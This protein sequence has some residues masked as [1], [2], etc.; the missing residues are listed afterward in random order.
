MRI[1][2]IHQEQLSKSRRS[3]NAS[4]PRTIFSP[5]H[6]LHPIMTIDA[7]R[8]Q[9]ICLLLC[10]FIK[11]LTFWLLSHFSFFLSKCRFFWSR[12]IRQEGLFYPFIGV[13]IFVKGI[14]NCIRIINS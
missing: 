2:H 5:I 11:V 10:D 9:H 6:S 4:I 7:I 14:D 8:G 13:E 1:T 12:H 3:A